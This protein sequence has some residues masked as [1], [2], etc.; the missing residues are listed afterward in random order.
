[1]LFDRVKKISESP[2]HLELVCRFV[3]T[4]VCIKQTTLY[5]SQLPPHYYISLLQVNMSCKTLIVSNRFPPH[6]LLWCHLINLETLA[7]ILE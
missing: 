5:S 6:S 1:M 7:T 4:S 2:A 3:I